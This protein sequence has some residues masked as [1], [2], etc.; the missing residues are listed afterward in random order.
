MAYPKK[1]KIDCM[2]GNNKYDNQVTNDENKESREL[3]N[4][5]PYKGYLSNCDI[6]LYFWLFF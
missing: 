4:D 2:S 1:V 5:M 6:L 3:K